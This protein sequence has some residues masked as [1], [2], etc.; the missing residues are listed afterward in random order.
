MVNPI[1]LI[2][3]FVSTVAAFI[4]TT[5]TSLARKKCQH[6]YSHKPLEEIEKVERALFPKSKEN[7]NDHDVSA[8]D[9]SPESENNPLLDLLP[10]P[11]SL[12]E[13]AKENDADNNH[14]ED[15]ATSLS[16]DITSTDQWKEAVAGELSEFWS[17]VLDPL[18]S[19]SSSNHNQD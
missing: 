4:S 14:D 12:K 1:P 5:S 16:F 15:H 3:I 17:R 6:Q 2:T 18:S 8:E 10:I 13:N 9:S 11:P 19:S 7:G